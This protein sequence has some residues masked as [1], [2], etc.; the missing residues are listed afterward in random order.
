MIPILGEL[1]TGKGKY[2]IHITDVKTFLQCR[3]RWAWSSNVR[4]NLQPNVTPIFYA[5]GKAVHEGLAHMYETGELAEDVFTRTLDD[6]RK[7]FEKITGPLWEEEQTKYDEARVLGVGM[8]ANYRKTVRDE[9]LDDDWEP[10]ATEMSF[11][12]PILTENGTPS[13]RVYLAGRFDGIFRRKSTGELWL[14]E[15]KT[16]AREPDARWLEMD[17]QPVIYSWAAQ[18][19][20]GQPIAG[21]HYRFLMKRVPER[22][23]KLKNGTFSRAINSSLHTTYVAYHE[24]LEIEAKE[25]ADRR[26][27][28]TYDESGLL[29]GFNPDPAVTKVTDATQLQ[30]KHEA[31]RQKQLINLEDEYRDILEQLAQRDSSEFIK[32]FEVRK[33]QAE[34]KQAAVDLWTISLEMVRDTTNIYPAPDW[35]KCTFCPF[36]SPCKV[37][38]AGGD[39]DLILIN[40]YRSRKEPSPVDE[41]NRVEW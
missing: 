25:R 10:V 16:S 12:V 38:N 22:P 21:I 2:E 6:E 18:Q 19:I 8:M 24:A 15:Y 32:E 13:S 4:M 3:R 1:T 39:P 27:G 28:A 41:D 20:L 5:V 14:R 34:I 30:A 7:D 31:H 23:H 37:M 29:L 26:Y 9:G 35:L 33:T 40:E 17:Y 11:S 36:R